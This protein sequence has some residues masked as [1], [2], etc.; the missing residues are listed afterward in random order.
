MFAEYIAKEIIIEN[1]FIL[2]INEIDIIRI[3][4]LH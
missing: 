3:T 4:I 2:K 1:T